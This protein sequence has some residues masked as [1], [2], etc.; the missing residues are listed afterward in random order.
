MRI[1]FMGSS[2]ASATC[3]RGI[4]RLPGLQVVGVVTQPDRPAGRGRD[5]TPCPCRR[6][7]AE[8]GIT[9]CITPENVNDAESVAWLRAKK[10]DVIVVVA[11]GQF[12]K[13][14]ILNMPP[15]GCVNCHFSL[16]PKYRGASPV[17]AALLAG[18]ELSGVS[19][20]RMGM[21]M[22]DG[23]I[24]R[25]Q[26]EPIYSDDTGETLMDKLAICGGVT[27]AKTL[28]LMAAGNLPPPVEQEDAK[29]TFAHKIRKTDGLIRWK[30][31]SSEIERLLRA[32]TPWPGCYTFL[33][34]RFRKKGNSG[35]VVVTGVEFLKT[36]QIE[37]SWRSELPGTVVALHR[38]GPVVRTG[39]GALLLTSLKA[40][41]ARELDGGTFLRGRALQPKTDMLL[42]A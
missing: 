8:R 18:D 3:L 20:I 17:T 25:R 27:L 39:D 32:Y 40:E 19:I 23:P 9:A 35:R 6:Y 31:R 26:V 34:A 41:G 5:L 30:Q 11:F 1:V 15:L 24:L 13:E 38:R 33:P 7:A 21:G 37:S 2:A 28:K 36:D 22:D 42:E 10:P 29:A 14:E 16:L 4:L 12:L